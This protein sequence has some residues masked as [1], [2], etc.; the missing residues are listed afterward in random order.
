[1]GMVT[2]S[3][4]SS[5]FTHHAMIILQAIKK[6]NNMFDFFNYFNKYG[7]NKTIFVKR[8]YNLLEHIFHQL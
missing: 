6:P 4:V 5:E 1:M 3:L 8:V 2:D 7:L